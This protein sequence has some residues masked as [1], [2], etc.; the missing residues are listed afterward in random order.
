MT[1][2]GRRTGPEGTLTFG[3]LE[4]GDDTSRA[5]TTSTAGHG[6]RR[7]WDDALWTVSADQWDRQQRDCDAITLRRG[8]AEAW[9]AGSRVWALLSFVPGLPAAPVTFGLTFTRRECLCTASTRGERLADPTGPVRRVDLKRGEACVSHR[10]NEGLARRVGSD[11]G[12]P[13][14]AGH[15]ALLHISTHKGRTA[16]RFRRVL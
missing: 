14:W 1:R 10:A 9:L 8:V 7:T 5:Q 2:Q 16:A 3:R 15:N 4:T 13:F 11:T 6:R 12:L